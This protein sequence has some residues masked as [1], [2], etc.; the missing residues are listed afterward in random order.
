MDG[1]I[2]IILCVLQDIVPCSKEKKIMRLGRKVVRLSI[3]ASLNLKRKPGC[4]I[5]VRR[6]SFVVGSSSFVRRS[7]TVRPERR[8]AKMRDIVIKEKLTSYE[9]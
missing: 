3:G 8:P 4:G 1:L 7:S 5:I 6:S 2:E 9:V